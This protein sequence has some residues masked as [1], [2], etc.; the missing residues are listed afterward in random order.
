[1]LTPISRV[2]IYDYLENCKRI[3]K[4]REWTVS[5]LESLGFEIIPSKAN[6]IFVKN[7]AIDGSVLYEELKKRGIL[8]R[9]FSDKKIS[10]Y[11]RVTIGSA[12]EMSVFID[13]VKTILEEKK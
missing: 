6:F 11:N 2:K 10:A 7:D 4:T 3:I 9:H 13:T 1:M 8:V 12:E 5:R